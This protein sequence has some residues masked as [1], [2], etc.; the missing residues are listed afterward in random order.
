[1]QSNLKKPLVILLGFGIPLAAVMVYGFL[2]L[3]KRKTQLN[4][5]PVYG[6]AIIVEKYKGPKSRGSIRYTFVNNGKVYEG[7]GRYLPHL[8][9]VNIGDTCEMVYARTNPKNSRLLED[10]NGLLKIRRKK[11][12]YFKEWKKYIEV[13]DSVSK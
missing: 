12:N 5:E 10:E 7:H 9:I 4:H 2:G 3:S 13:V 6:I 1:M 11:I 8:E